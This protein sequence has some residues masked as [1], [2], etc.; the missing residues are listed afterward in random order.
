MYLA[1][2]DYKPHRLLRWG[3]AGWSLEEVDFADGP[4]GS[5]NV[6]TTKLTPGATTGKGVAITADSTTGINSGQGFLSTDVGRLVRIEHGSAWGWAVIGAVNS[7][8]SVTADIRRA[9]GAATPIDQWRLGA[10]SDTTGWPRAVTF[11][12]SRAAWAGTREQPQT[13]W[14]SQSG[15]FQNMQ[16]DDGAGLVADDDAIARTVASQTVNRSCGC[17]RRASWWRARR[18]INSSCART[19]MTGRLPRSTSRSSRRPR[20]PAP[21]WTPSPSTRRRSSPRGASG[22]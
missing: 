1:S 22:A 20:G 4:W 12:E 7:K 18:P 17:C 11:Y 3:H 16:P 5:V 8:V 14:M 15:D 6:T 9:F 21:M 10:W 13:V 19:W 2:P